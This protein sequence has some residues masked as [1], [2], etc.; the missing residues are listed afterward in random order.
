MPCNNKF[1]SELDL[2]Q[3]DYEPVTLIVGTFNPSWP[4]NNTEWFYG[5]TGSNYLWD[6]LP[7][8]YGE[9]SLID[10]GSDEWKQFAR[11]KQIAFT[12]LIRSVED[13]EEGNR[14]HAKILGG[15]SDKAIAYHFDDFDFVNIVKLLQRRPS[16]KNVYLTRGITEAFWRHVWNP[17]MQY[18]N[19]NQLHERRLLSPTDEATYQHEAYNT[20]HPENNISRLEDYVLMRW[21][22]EWH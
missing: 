5:R 9:I 4:A 8:L 19:L 11:D 21:K 14:E 20:Q 7:R 1:L 22:E 13:A 6:V 15:F 10:A 18:C 2:G 3:I 12:D 17:A 16:I